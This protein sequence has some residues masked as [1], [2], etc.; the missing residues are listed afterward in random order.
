MRVASAMKISLQM[1]RL[2]EVR[3]AD[4][5]VDG[6][7]VIRPIKRCAQGGTVEPL[8][9]LGVCQRHDCQYTFIVLAN[10]KKA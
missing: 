2:R 9:L 6:M 3:D 10:F 8:H 7:P 4:G 1:M 5:W